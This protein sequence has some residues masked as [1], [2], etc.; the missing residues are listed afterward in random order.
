MNAKWMVDRGET[1][2]HLVYDPS[3]RYPRRACDR[4]VFI[5]GADAEVVGASS[6]CL[7]CAE[8]ENLWIKSGHAFVS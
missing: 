7:R 4:R 3:Q 6:S 8:I 5:G 2:S 1:V